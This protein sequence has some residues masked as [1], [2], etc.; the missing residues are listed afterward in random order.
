MKVV[1][2]RVKKAEV[3]V[4]SKITGKINKGI[5]IL[6]GVEENDSQKDADYLAEKIAELRIFED[7][8]GKMNLSIQEIKGEFLVVSQFTILCNCQD[9]RRP[10]F[11]KAARPEAAEKLYGYF[12][13]RLK[14]YSLPV[15]TGE[16]KAMME[17]EL[18][19]DGP[20]TFII[21]SKDV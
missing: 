20:V 14:K 1:L 15:E 7:T 10:S 3:R 8:N 2:Q 9:G 17:V 6:L 19:N 5:V 16:F 11:D 18:V 12:V 4:S 13:E 21:D